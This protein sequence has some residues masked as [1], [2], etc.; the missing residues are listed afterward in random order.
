MRRP[1]FANPMV[2]FRALGPGEK[3][4]AMGLETM[5]IRSSVTPVTV[6]VRTPPPSSD[7]FNFQTKPPSS[8][9]LNHVLPWHNQHSDS[10]IFGIAHPWTQM[11][12]GGLFQKVTKQI[13]PKTELGA[14]LNKKTTSQC[15]FKPHLEDHRFFMQFVVPGKWIPRRCALGTIYNPVQCDC[16]RY[17]PANEAPVGK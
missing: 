13:K 17:A 6:D 7:L 3:K 1:T 11:T 5:P 9:L 8:L 16:S 4:P 2:L 10:E 15:L 14:V 12:T